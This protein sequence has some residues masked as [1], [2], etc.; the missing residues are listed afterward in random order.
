[1]PLVSGLCSLSSEPIGHRPRIEPDACTNSK[2]WNAIRL[3]EFVTDNPRNG[4]KGGQLCRGHR[5]PKSFDPIVQSEWLIFGDRLWRPPLSEFEIA[6][7]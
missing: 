1:M 4:E 5:A 7:H 2:G 3:R 6:M